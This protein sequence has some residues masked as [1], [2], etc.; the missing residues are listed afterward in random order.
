MDYGSIYYVV[1]SKLEY[2][3]L[4]CVSLS[5][6]NINNKKIYTYTVVKVS[7]AVMCEGRRGSRCNV[8]HQV[9]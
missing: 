4:I 5:D 6:Q 1:K 2:I 7:E 3:Y 8:R 9:L